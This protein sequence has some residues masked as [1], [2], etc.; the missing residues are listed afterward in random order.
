MRYRHVARYTSLIVEKLS[1]HLF[2]SPLVKG[3]GEG[4]ELSFR[5]S[6]K[7]H[8]LSRCLRF[9]ARESDRRSPIACPTRP[10]PTIFRPTNFRKIEMDRFDRRFAR[11]SCRSRDNG[12]PKETQ[13][14]S[15]AAETSEEQVWL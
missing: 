13:M 3:R 10:A 15:P 12:L 8:P 14:C 9:H 1:P 5:F 11:G 6:H 2:S 7:F 4:E